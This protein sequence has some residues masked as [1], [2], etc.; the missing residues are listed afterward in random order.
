MFV[1]E[2][3]PNIQTGRLTYEFRSSRK[4][5]D[6]FEDFNVDERVIVNRS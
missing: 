5:I 3:C 6:N 1:F 2:E 4:Y